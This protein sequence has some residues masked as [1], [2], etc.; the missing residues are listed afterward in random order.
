M[1]EE[2]KMDVFR[3]MHYSSMMDEMRGLQW[4]R[5]VEWKEFLPVPQS[6]NRDR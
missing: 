5:R 4:K 1:H 2:N 3:E 6:N